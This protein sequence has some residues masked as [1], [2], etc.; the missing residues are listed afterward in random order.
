[1]LLSS[2]SSRVLSFPFFFFFSPKRIQFSVFLGRAFEK[3]FKKPTAA[4]ATWA[5]KR[6]FRRLPRTCGQRSENDDR[7]ATDAYDR[8]I[9]IHAVENT[10]T[11]VVQRPSAGAREQRASFQSVFVIFSI[12]SWD[13]TRVNISRR[14]VS[15]DGFKNRRRRVPPRVRRVLAIRTARVV[16]E[17]IISGRLFRKCIKENT[18][19]RGAS[20]FR[21][22]RPPQMLCAPL[23]TP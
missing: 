14:F 19:K 22:L 23:S 16:K 13:I 1:M 8:I 20:I 7:S 10:K 5:V 18:S 21:A 17:S 3:M 4:T 2:S 6:R 9:I 15:R 11:S 12:P